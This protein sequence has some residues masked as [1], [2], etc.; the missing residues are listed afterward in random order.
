MPD[1]ARVPRRAAP[2][3]PAA[4]VWPAMRNKANLRN[5]TRAGRPRHVGESLRKQ[6]QFAGSRL[7]AGVPGRK[8]EGATGVGMGNKA[9]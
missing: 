3:S 2:G 1:G 7:E 5:K 8:E 6:S 9:S 4:P